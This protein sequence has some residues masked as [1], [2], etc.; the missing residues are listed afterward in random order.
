MTEVQEIFREPA[1]TTGFKI[2]GKSVIRVDSIEKVT[3]QTIYGFD[4]ELPRMLHAKLKRSHLAHA[5]IISIDTQQAEQLL[6]VRAVLTHRDLPNILR[7]VAIK[8]TPILA[9][10]R[11]R[12]VGDPIAA[13]A[14][15]TIEIAE[16]ALELIEVEYQ[17]LPAVLDPEE[18]L[19]ENP[20]VIIHPDLHNYKAAALHPARAVSHLPNASNLFQVRKG[21]VEAGFHEAD[22]VIENR[23]TSHMAH[24]FHLEPNV[25]VAKVE[26]NDQV[27]IWEST[28]CP[29]QLRQ[30]ISEALQIPTDRIRVVGPHVGGAFGNKTTTHVGPI[31]IALAK[32]TGRP[33]RLGLTREETFSTTH[34]R[35]PF[36]IYIKDG[37]KSDGT[38]IAREMKVI[39]NGGAYSG[40]FGNNV[41]RSCVTG[42]TIYDIASFKFE[43]YRV[44]TNQVQGGAFRGFG[45]GQVSWAVEVQMDKIAEKLGLDPLEIR[46]KNLLQEGDVNALGE[47]VYP[48]DYKGL[49]KEVGLTL[50]MQRGVGSTRNGPWLQGKGIA[51]AHKWS[52]A[53]TASSAYVKLTDEGSAEVWTSTIDMGTGAHTILSQI[54]AETLNLALDKVKVVMPDT[55]L[56]PFADGGFSTR[57]TYNDG[58]A[59][60]LA[61]LDL[62]EQILAKAALKIGARAEDLELQGGEVYHKEKPN[63][64]VALRDL[65]V[66]SKTRSGGFMP[67]QDIFGRATWQQEV[68]SLDPETGQ[69][70]TERAASFYDAV[71][72]GVE[73]EVNEETGQIRVL[74]M[75]LG[76]EPGRAINPKLLEGQIEGGAYLGYTTSLYEELVLENGTI[77][78]PDLKDYKI[79]GSLDVPALKTIILETPF[80]DGPYGAKGVGEGGVISPSPAIGNAVFDAVGIRFHDLPITAEKIMKEIPIRAIGRPTQT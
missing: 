38:V 29:Y 15:D 57:Q 58:N 4:F 3:G 54:T 76:T 19:S 65:F 49:L 16:E 36:V 11:V 67:G 10:D 51:I 48:V 24:H 55:I 47:R 66:W 28:Q 14:A 17:E 53:P 9:S 27:T 7:G 46:M 8:D 31:T 5:K 42:A 13:V 32:R 73:L 40:G 26:R 50:G 1:E 62:R 78:N 35:H 21:N 80:N 45:A 61:A 77:M 74:K 79:A 72:T 44:Y 2:I 37:V 6:G 68:G 59:V 23:Y 64:R 69:C 18:A 43:A 52:L 34:V 75:I 70:S 60:R 39:L 22:F 71:A 41:T 20:P 33:V 12:Y 25:S 63:Q 30:E 56:T